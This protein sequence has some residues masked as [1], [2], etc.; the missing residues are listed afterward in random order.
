MGHAASTSL[1]ICT[2]AHNDLATVELSPLRNHGRGQAEDTSRGESWVNKQKRATLLSQPREGALP[3]ARYADIA[4]LPVSF[5]EYQIQRFGK[6]FPQYSPEQILA[7]FLNEMSE[8]RET[9]FEVM[10]DFARNRF[11]PVSPE[12]RLSTNWLTAA[13]AAY[14]PLG[15]MPESTFKNWQKRGIIRMESH[16]K[17]EPANAA[18]VLTMRMLDRRKENIFP[19]TLASGEPGYWCAVVEAPSRPPEVIPVEQIPL[20]PPSSIVW[21]PWAGAAWQERWH[22]IG[23]NEANLGAIRFAG[24]KLVRGNLWWAVDLADLA[25]WDEQAASLYVQAVGNHE[26]LVEDIATLV[27]DRLFFGKI[28]RWNEQTKTIHHSVTC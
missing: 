22:L 23:E 15:T 3:V 24:T 5:A 25:A 1:R 8:K 7:L 19:D 28:P 18:A 27:L 26:R 12:L 11:E 2:H 6:Q 10:D 14:D 21:T 9:A 20:L 13:L 17:P 4:P 16:G